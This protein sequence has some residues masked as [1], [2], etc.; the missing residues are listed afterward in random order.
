MKLAAS[1]YLKQLNLVFF[2]FFEAFEERL[3]LTLSINLASKN[4]KE[5][6]SKCMILAIFPS[7]FCHSKQLGENL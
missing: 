7:A 5:T 6:C 1:K 3:N 2:S 4:F